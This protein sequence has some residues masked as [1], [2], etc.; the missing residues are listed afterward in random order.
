MRPYGI[1]PLILSVAPYTALVCMLIKPLS[2]YVSPDFSL[3]AS[4]I[5]FLFSPTRY[6]HTMPLGV[7]TS[8]SFQF[9]VTDGSHV[10]PNLSFRFD[11]VNVNKGKIALWIRP[12]EVRANFVR[13]KT[14][15]Q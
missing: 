3:T 7:A 12:L 14:C 11:F 10:T 15:E 4:A 9:Y 8:D 2:F 5:G 6:V 13:C 1:S